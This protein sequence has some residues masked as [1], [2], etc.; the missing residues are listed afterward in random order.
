MTDPKYH[1]ISSIEILE[2]HEPMVLEDCD[3]QTV[4]SMTGSNTF[5]CKAVLLPNG[6]K[7]PIYSGKLVENK[8]IQ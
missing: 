1:F 8:T 5:F 4:Y 6:T 3:S 7:L 2:I